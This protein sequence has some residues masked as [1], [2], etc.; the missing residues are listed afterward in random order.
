MRTRILTE[1]AVAVAL[2]TVVGLFKIPLP[3][4]IYGGSVSLETLPVL[5]VACRR[6]WRAGALAGAALGT[7]DFLL[8][9]VVVHPVQVLID[10]PVAFGALGWAAGSLGH[11][12]TD[13]WP[14]GHPI[15]ARLRVLVAIL[16]GN[17]ARLAAHFASGIIYFAAYTPAGQSVWLYSL[18]YNLS[19]LVPQAVFHIV[20]LQLVM[21]ILTLQR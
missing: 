5:V 6:G 2:A 18:L 15:L 1:I 3:H 16:A 21:R 19:Y 7:V 17:G 8:K 11:V 4:L 9:P 10:Y 12:A 14:T 20:L 13:G